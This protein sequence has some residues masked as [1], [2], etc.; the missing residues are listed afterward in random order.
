MNSEL[1]VFRSNS[2]KYGYQNRSGEV[3]I[4]PVYD[5]AR[6]FSEGL[7]AVNLGYEMGDG[8]IDGNGDRIW[9]M[10]NSGKWGFINEKGEVVIPI[11][12][13][14]ANSFS[15]GFALLPNRT[16]IDKTGKVAITL[17]KHYE[18]V[19]DF[20]GGFARIWRSGLFGY[21]DRSGKVVVPAV[22]TKTKIEQTPVEQLIAVSDQE[23]ILFSDAERWG[24]KNHL[25]DIIIPAS[26]NV[27][28][29]FSDEMA[30]VERDGNWFYINKT[31]SQATPYL[32]YDHTDNF[33]HGFARVR[34]GKLWGYINKVGKEVVPVRYELEILSAMPVERLVQINSEQKSPGKPD[35]ETIPYKSAEKWGFLNE[36]AE[37]IIAPK[38]KS[39]SKF[40][41]GMIRVELNA[42]YGF[43]DALG[44]HIIPCLYQ[45]ATDFCE[46][47]AIVERDRIQGFIDK[48]GKETM[49][50]MY[51]Y[52]SS[53]HDGIAKVSETKD[54][55]NAKYGYID[56]TGKELVPP[57]YNSLE[58]IRL[59][60]S[61]KELIAK[62][63]KSLQ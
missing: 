16:F 22:H 47:V 28:C 7:A 54:G 14:H 60:L 29:A 34:S 26:F 36:R 42:K 8:G 53:F 13:K 63:N 19:E 57:I 1:K 25:G 23:P 41:E 11:I 9:T 4:E 49:L 35:P 32:T 56:K 58:L 10:I 17:D 27:A 40:V 52:I 6:D 37:I 20:K 18:G 12:H 33:A 15:E 55:V 43:V 48:T 31:G 62:H 3:V 21:I 44:Q 45:H 50:P 2:G 5:L 61:P 46:G 30:L 59:K 24:Y 39:I 38:F 51:G